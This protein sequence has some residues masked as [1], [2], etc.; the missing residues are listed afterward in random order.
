MGMEQDMKHILASLMGEQENGHVDG[1]FA[2]MKAFVRDVRTNPLHREF[3]VDVE[4][5]LAEITEEPEVLDDPA[6]RMA[7]RVLYN[8]AIKMLSGMT[9]FAFHL[10]T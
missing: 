1:F 5:V 10:P 3:V 9:H 2:N 7:L 4:E 8:S 6:A